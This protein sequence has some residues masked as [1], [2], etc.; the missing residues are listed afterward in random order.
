MH[1]IVGII[2]FDAVQ[3]TSAAS[4]QAATNSLTV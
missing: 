2:T 1:T 4:T 3:K